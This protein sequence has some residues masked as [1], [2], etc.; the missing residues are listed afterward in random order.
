MRQH[1]SPPPADD[2]TFPAHA[3]AK[4]LQPWCPQRALKGEPRN[5]LASVLS[6]VMHDVLSHK[7]LI[8][9]SV[10]IENRRRSG[11]LPLCHWLAF[12]GRSHAGAISLCD[13]AQTQGSPFAK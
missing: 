13:A 1:E 7:S 4:Y 11:H 10:L 3:Y 2:T 5:A 6:R 12:I 8:G 9:D